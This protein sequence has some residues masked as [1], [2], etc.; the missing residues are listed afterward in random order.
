MRECVHD[1]LNEVSSQR[2]RFHQLQSLRRA[3]Y[4][5]ERESRLS[6]RT[7]EKG[8]NPEGQRQQ[9]W[10]LTLAGLLCLWWWQIH[11][12]KEHIKRQPFVGK[13]WIQLRRHFRRRLRRLPFLSRSFWIKR[14]PSSLARQLR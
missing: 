10:P 2:S 14:H 5:L 8:E 13:R 12:E 3:P 4:E 6:R 9:A 7:Q 11:F 1:Y